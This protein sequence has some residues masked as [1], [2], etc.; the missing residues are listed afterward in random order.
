MWRGTKLQRNSFGL[1]SLFRSG[2]KYF[3]Q[4]DARKRHNSNG[5][6][7]KATTRA[8]A[9]AAATVKTGSG[10]RGSA[11]RRT[12][13]RRVKTTQ[14]WAQRGSAQQRTNETSLVHFVSF[15]SLI[16]NFHLKLFLW[17]SVRVCFCLCVYVY[18]G[19]GS[20]LPQ[21]LLPMLLAPLLCPL[22]ALL[23]QRRRHIQ[24]FNILC[25]VSHSPHSCIANRNREF[26]DM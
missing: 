4:S 21:S 15:R 25:T 24:S 18:F 14:S 26:T 5:E 1:I 13:Q 2:R 11:G 17:A 9:A 16:Q 23:N 20:A 7:A 6:T 12:Q 10:L 22:P 3:Q 19:S 8:A